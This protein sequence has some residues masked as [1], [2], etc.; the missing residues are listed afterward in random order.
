MKILSLVLPCYNEGEN[1]N[2]L[3]DTVTKLQETNNNIEIIIVENGSKDDSLT[4]IKNHLIYK[5]IL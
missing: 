5:K 1:I 4:K 2:K 3:L